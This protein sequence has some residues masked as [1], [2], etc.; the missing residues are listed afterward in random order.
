MADGPYPAC[1]L[2]VD[3]CELRMVLIILN[4]WKKS[5]RIIFVTVEMI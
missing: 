4:G 2:F 3:G 1:C 5:K